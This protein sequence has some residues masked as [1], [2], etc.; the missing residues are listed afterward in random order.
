L[1]KIERSE[2]ID[3]D[4]EFDRDGLEGLWRRYQYSIED[5]RNGR[6]NPTKIDIE[7][8][9]LNRDLAF[10]RTHIQAYRAFRAGHG[11][12]DASAPELDSAEAEATRTFGLER[13]LQTA[14]R[15]NI[16]QLEEGLQIV[17]S[18]AET[19]VE[20]GF[21]DILAKDISGN[22]VVIELKAESTRPAA[23]AQILAYM[24]C[25]A[26]ERGGSV[27]GILVGADFDL[28]VEFA[29]RAVSNL[30]LKRYRFRFEFI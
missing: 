16:Q 22:W 11:A 19:K 10:Y 1:K 26:S 5:L 20:A 29:A 14:L 6:P 4:A 24:G 25:V 15:A 13:D 7:P 27:R 8:E 28:R 12:S 23:V 21:I 18:G 2:G 30:T 9:K 17:D 3:L